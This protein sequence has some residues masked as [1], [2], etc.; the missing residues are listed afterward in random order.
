MFL[1]FALQLLISIIF[2][3]VGRV[4][5][6]TVYIKAELQG[7]STLHNF[8]LFGGGGIAKKCTS[9]S[10]SLLFLKCGMSILR[11]IV[12]N[13]CMPSISVYMQARF[14]LETHSIAKIP[15]DN[16]FKAILT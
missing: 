3:L 6:C 13:Y 12:C 2:Y 9:C 11:T 10:Q 8:S 14:N 5:Q 16:L 7:R 1:L 15:S 4:W